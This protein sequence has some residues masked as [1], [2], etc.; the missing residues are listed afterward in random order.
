MFHDPLRYVCSQLLAMFGVCV[1]CCE[2][3]D[4]IQWAGLRA[5][6]CVAVCTYDSFTAFLLMCGLIS[7]CVCCLVVSAAPPCVHS[8]P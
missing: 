4:C 1:C 8:G 2:Q 5:M 6:K 3:V 7:L